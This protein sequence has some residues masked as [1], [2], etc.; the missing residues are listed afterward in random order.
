MSSDAH[1]ADREAY[2]AEKAEAKR[3]PKKFL[4]SLYG[5]NYRDELAKTFIEDGPTVGMVQSEVSDSYGKLKK[6]F[7][8]YKTSI[9]EEF[10][11][12]DRAAAER[13][14]HGYLT[15]AR[16]YIKAQKDSYPLVHA[17][18]LADNVAAVIQGHLKET[19]GEDESGNYVPGEL[20]TFEEASKRM[21]SH[22]KEK[23]EAAAKLTAAKPDASK[24]GEVKTRPPEST[25]KTLTQQLTG[26]LSQSQTQKPET[27]GERR[28]RAIAAGEAAAAK[29]KEQ[30]G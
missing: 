6:E 4:Q 24:A 20:L 27:E 23:Y 3:N 1:K 22:L 26:N 10:T 21:E 13:Q 7:E 15:Q 25:R 18:G 14:M 16:A 28:R 8:D 19:E 30:G 29:R 17:F 12:R 2:L 5:E 9:K 11:Q